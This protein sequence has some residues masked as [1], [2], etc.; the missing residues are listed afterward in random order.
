MKHLILSVA[1]ISVFTCQA[2]ETATVPKAAAV[3]KIKNEIS[4]GYGYITRENTLNGMFNFSKKYSLNDSNS[5][6]LSKLITYKLFGNYD[7]VRFGKTTRSGAMMIN[8]RHNFLPWLSGGVTAGYENESVELYIENKDANGKYSGTSAIG[9]YS[10]SSF[11]LAGELQFIYKQLGLKT[12]YGIFGLGN[13]FITGKYT[14][15][16]SDATERYSAI[17]I[18]PQI[19]PFGMRVGKKLAGFGEIGFGYKGIIH[20][21]A[22][23]SF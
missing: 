22:A 18:N 3:P 4:A 16:T 19:T 9:K 13:A 8:Y 7:H 12:Y 2:Q 20:L 11:T 17:Y 10:R 5:Y 21:G 1:A 23:Y 15:K 6:I 14:S